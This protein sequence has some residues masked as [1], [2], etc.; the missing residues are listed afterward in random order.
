MNRHFSL[1]LDIVRFLAAVC[2]LLSHGNAREIVATNLFAASL[3]HNAVIVFFLLSGYVIA[4]VADTRETTPRSFWVSRLARIYSVALPA[5]L[6][7]PFLDRIGEAFDPGLY[8]LNTT[9]DYWW[10]RIMASL[11]FLNELWLVSIMPFSNSPYWSLCYEMCYYLLFSVYCF[12]TGRRRTIML[13]ILC[14]VMGPKILLL[15]PIWVVGVF[16][17]RYRPWH[18]VSERRGWIL[19]GLSVAG[20][21]AYQ[22]FEVYDHLTKAFAQ[23]V[24]RYLFRELNFSKH[25]LADYVLTCLIAMNFVGVRA[26][27]HRLMPFLGSV[28]ILFKHLSAYTFAVYLFHLPLLLLFA[29]VIRGDP[30]GYAYYLSTVG[31]VLVACLLVGVATEAFK[32]RLKIWFDL[33]IAQFFSGAG[34][35]VSAQQ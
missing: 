10:L 34:R 18:Q 28:R 32:D 21:V 15:F 24:G 22:Y 19:L 3:G 25:F 31:L 5:V 9:H 27:A 26:V 23:M 20:V 12:E 8:E 29:A 35:K 6:L 16:L 1:Y 30:G 17:Y 14:L 33:R 2:V 4:Y 7:T 11:L 13:V